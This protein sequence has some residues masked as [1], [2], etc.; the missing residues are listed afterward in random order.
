MKKWLTIL[1]LMLFFVANTNAANSDFLGASE[2]VAAKGGTNL[3]YQGFD[4]AGVIR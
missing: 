4:K 3:V 2:G 1:S